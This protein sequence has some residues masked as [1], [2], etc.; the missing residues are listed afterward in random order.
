MTDIIEHDTVEELAVVPGFTI[1][2]HTLRDMLVAGLL[3]ASKD[4]TLPTIAT[5]RLE[6]DEHELQLV[7]TDRYR[8]LVATAHTDYSNNYVNAGAG[9]VL[10]HQK[11]A[12]DLVKAL[13]KAS[14]RRVN[15]ELVRVSV[16][17]DRVMVEGNGWSRSLTIVSGDFPKYRTLIPS[18]FT[19]TE[20]IAVNPRFL[21]DIAKIPVDKGTPVRLRFVSETRP[22][23]AVLDG[24]NGVSKYL[25]LLMPVRIPS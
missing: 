23:L 2:A 5:V 18:E 9:D 11:D 20:T 1:A 16:V 8:L 21:A 15:G 22:M 10:I 4:D 6:W 17:A 7:A 14:P 12:A 19:P 25:Y 13:P 3:A 24:A